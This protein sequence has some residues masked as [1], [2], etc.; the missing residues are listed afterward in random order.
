VLVGL[1]RPHRPA[2]GPWWLPTLGERWLQVR[3]S[4]PAHGCYMERMCILECLRVRALCSCGVALKPQ[5]TPNCRPATDTCAHLSECVTPRSAQFLC[6]RSYSD[7]TTSFVVTLPLS[8]SIEDRN[9]ALAWEAAFVQVWA[10]LPAQLLPTHLTI[11]Q[12]H[13]A[14]TSASH[15]LANCLSVSLYGAFVP[16]CVFRW[17]NC[18]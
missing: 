7:N 18:S 2:R 6:C 4:D 1:W 11:N 10:G 12:M 5:A 13:C 3:R 14:W 15:V 17:L 8:S 16:C 9:A